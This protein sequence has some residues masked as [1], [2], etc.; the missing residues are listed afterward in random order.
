MWGGIKRELPSLAADSV[1]G[2]LIT[3]HCQ[4]KVDGTRMKGICSNYATSESSA[5][6]WLAGLCFFYEPKL[7]ILWSRAGARLDAQARKHLL[8]GLCA[9]PLTRCRLLSQQARD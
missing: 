1:Q 4:E 8:L 5:H 9:D 3:Q 7:L 6:W 2:H